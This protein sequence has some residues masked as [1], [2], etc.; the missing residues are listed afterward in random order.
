MGQYRVILAVCQIVFSFFSKNVGR[1]FVDWV[2]D[3]VLRGIEVGVNSECALVEV[4][5][6]VDEDEEAC[7]SEVFLEGGHGSVRTK[8]MSSAPSVKV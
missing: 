1:F 4:S 6:D 8:A 7:E 3:E 2:V 5:E